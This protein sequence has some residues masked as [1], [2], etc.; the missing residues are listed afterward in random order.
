MERIRVYDQRSARE[1]ERET[2]ERD[3]RER[4]KRDRDA[5]RERETE[6]RR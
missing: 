2:R 5:Q 4:D 3:K 1:K 6:G